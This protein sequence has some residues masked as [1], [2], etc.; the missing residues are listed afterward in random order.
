ME[1]LRERGLV[2]A[3]LCTHHRKAL[4]VCLTASGMLCCSFADLKVYLKIEN[5]LQAGGAAVGVG[6]LQV[7]PVSS[8]TSKP[9]KHCIQWLVRMNAQ[10]S[11]FYISYDS[12]CSSSASC[13]YC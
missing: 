7:V 13:K 3:C 6:A 5:I 10:S 11:S 1:R 12:S 4:A 8:I 9:C 2:A